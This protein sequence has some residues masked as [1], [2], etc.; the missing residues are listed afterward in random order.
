MLW[1]ALKHIHQGFYIDA[2]AAWPDKHSVSKALYDKG[3][4]G[5]NIDPNPVFYQLLQE[6]RSRD[7]NLLVA[8]DE[9]PGRMTLNYIEGT[10]LSTFDAKITQFHSET[11][12][13]IVPKEIQ[14]TTLAKVWGEFIPKKY[15]VHFLKIDVEGLERAVIAGNDWQKNR[16]WIVVV[17][18]LSPVTLLDSSA[19]WE[20]ILFK[21]DYHFV[22]HDGL[23]RFYVA[24]EHPE[25]LSVFKY[26]PNIF[27]GFLPSN[28]QKSEA[29]AAEAEANMVQ[30]NSRADTAEARAAEAEANMVQANSRAD[31]AEARA[32]EAEAN[33]VQANSRADTAEARA[34]EAEA[35]MVQA[36]S[37]ADTAEAR[38]AEAEANMVQANSRADTA[39][40]RVAEAEANMVQANIR[41]QRITNSRS[42]RMTAPLRNTAGGMRWFIRGSLAWLTLKPGS[43]PRRIVR[44]ILMRLRNWVNL[45]PKLKSIILSTLLRLPKLNEWLRKRHYTEPIIVTQESNDE[46]IVPSQVMT[47]QL[48]SS[49]FPTVD[50]IENKLTHAIKKWPLGK[51]I[52]E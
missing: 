32:A 37:R 52:Y 7:V 17:E 5:I 38:V 20:P 22:Y 35:N 46:I 24:E 48:S 10:G 18:S 44:F 28:Q 2:G 45:R 6:K 39:E 25:L 23:N 13:K 41:Y 34:A 30:A 31:T 29:R 15:D 50:S 3:W 47:H 42:W 21:A 49:T 27:D 40:A 33:M 51:R 8:L 1:R 19:E 36:N 9:T 14:T 11:G 4:Y 43:R 16:P 12:Y 26:P